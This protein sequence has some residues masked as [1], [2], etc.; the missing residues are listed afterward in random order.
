MATTDIERLR[1][2]LLS[3]RTIDIVT[4]GARTG[5]LRTTEIWFTRIGDE[6]FICGTPGGDGSSGAPRPRDWLA[7][8]RA[9]PDFVF[10]FKESLDAEVDA[11]AQVVTDPAERERVFAAPETQ[12]YRDQVGSVRPLVEGSPLVKVTFTGAAAPLN[13]ST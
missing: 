12:W 10:R 2:A 13:G 1:Q 11:R 6:V 8:L 3:D 4:R 5:R 9:N 7:N